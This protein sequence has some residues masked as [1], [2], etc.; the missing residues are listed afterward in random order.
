V[1]NSPADPGRPVRSGPAAPARPNFAFRRRNCRCLRGG[2]ITQI[3]IGGN[4]AVRS[5][6]RPE[7]Q[8][9][10]HVRSEH[11]SH[12]PTALASSVRSLSGRTAYITTG[13]NDL[14]SILGIP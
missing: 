5:T 7:R 1:I 14:V 3:R 9:V 10:A 13:L 6:G 2:Q 4:D 12:S 11:Q 8:V